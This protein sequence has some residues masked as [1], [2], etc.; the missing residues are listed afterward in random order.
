MD[1]GTMAQWAAALIGL[2]LG[3]RSE[4]R[5]FRDRKRET[6]RYDAAALAK[7]T[8]L[9]DQALVI[10]PAE[11]GE[12]AGGV[13]DS[14]FRRLSSASRAAVDAVAASSVDSAG[15]LLQVC[16]LL[17][18]LAESPE[19]LRAPHSRRSLET[20]SELN[21]ALL[22]LS[23]GAVSRLQLRGK[24]I[25]KSTFEQDR[26]YREFKARHDKVRN[27]LWLQVMG[28]PPLF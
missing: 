2:F 9:L 1:I 20:F 23:I 14:D 12:A 11:L 15:L 4:F 22:L 10:L 19:L 16:D 5:A 21:H 13:T 24:E 26:F 3:L 27:Q 17:D 7:V 28:R 18:G 6:S 25:T 8:D